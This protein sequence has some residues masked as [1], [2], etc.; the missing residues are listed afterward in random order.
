MR[1]MPAAR[2]CCSIAASAPVP[3][4]IIVSTVATPMVMPIVVSAV[5]S[6]LRDSARRAMVKLDPMDMTRLP[7]GRNQRQFAHRQPLL[8]VRLIR[9]NLAILEG[10]DARPV[11]GD[12]LF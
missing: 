7:G 3:S 9:H 8:A 2:P 10:D 6:L 12:L 4:A 5:W 1:F 11:F